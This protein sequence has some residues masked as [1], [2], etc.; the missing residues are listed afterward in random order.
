MFDGRS[1]N[2]TLQPQAHA[3]LS[4]PRG[5]GR[6]AGRGAALP[7][8]PRPW[9]TLFNSAVCAG[10]VP[11]V[12]NPNGIGPLA[13][14][15]ANL[16]WYRFQEPLAA[17]LAVPGAV[18]V[19]SPGDMVALNGRTSDYAWYSTAVP[20]SAVRVALEVSLFTVTF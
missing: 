2:V 18:M 14:V 7:I 15:A 10:G 9:T 8:E 3:L 17:D 20:A 12:G 13:L 6:G 19:A 4:Q 16:S 5:A 1:V 11:C